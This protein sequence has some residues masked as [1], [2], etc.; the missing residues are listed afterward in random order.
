MLC[1]LDSPMK[2][3]PYIKW[4]SSRYKSENKTIKYFR[5][6]TWECLHHHK[7][8]QKFIKQI[9][10]EST[11]HKRLINWTWPV[12]RTSVYQ[13]MPVRKWKRQV[14]EWEKVFIF[15]WKKTD[16]DFISRIHKEWLKTEKNNLKGKR[17]KR[18]V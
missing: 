16:K 15:I 2:K 4:I 13:K 3:R 8:R 12:I 10:T 18:Y 14:T 17:S 5:R 6:I 11:N 1:L 9:H 7:S